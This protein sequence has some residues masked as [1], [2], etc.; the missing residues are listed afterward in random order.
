MSN[1]WKDE[2]MMRYK[3][4]DIPASIMHKWNKFTN[5]RIRQITRKYEYLRWFVKTENP[6]MEELQQETKD[7]DIA[8][9]PDEMPDK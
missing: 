6:T 3:L 7:Y 8:Y 4:P 2:E 9:P 5:N 1:E